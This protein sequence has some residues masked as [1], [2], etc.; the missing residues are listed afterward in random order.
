MHEDVHE[1][2]HEAS[3]LHNCFLT[4]GAELSRSSFGTLIREKA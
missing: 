1:D 3:V 4:E 2:V